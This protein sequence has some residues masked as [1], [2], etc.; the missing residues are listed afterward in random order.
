MDKWILLIVTGFAIY[1]TFEIFRWF[2]MINNLSF[3]D[4][5][6]FLGVRGS[7]DPIRNFSRSRRSTWLLFPILLAIAITIRLI[8]ATAEAF[9]R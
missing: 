5:D 1:G 6:K 7:S 2:L 9:F 4:F 8:L 3:K